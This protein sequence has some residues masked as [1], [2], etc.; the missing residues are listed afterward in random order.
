MREK[1]IKNLTAMLSSFESYFAPDE[2][3]PLERE[4]D[5]IIKRRTDYY[6]NKI[7]AVSSSK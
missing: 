4:R 6:K 5:N 7:Q 2:K 1:A 3:T